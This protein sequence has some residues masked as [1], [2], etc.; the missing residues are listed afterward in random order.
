VT[1]EQHADTVRPA[2]KP[3]R[4]K[5]LG[6]ADDEYARMLEAQG[7]GCAICGAKPK[8]RRLHVDHDHATGKVRGLLCHRCNRAL[9]TWIDERWLYSAANY[10]RGWVSFPREVRP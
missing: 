3:K 2:R 5:Q 4:A 10:L 1:A 6:V 7:G 9:P 8:T